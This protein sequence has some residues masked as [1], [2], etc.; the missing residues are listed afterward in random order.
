MKKIYNNLSIV[1][2]ISVIIKI[3]GLLY[4]ILTTRLLGL[5]GM[6]L[7]SL[8]TPLLSLCL[9]ISS[10]SIQQVCNQ[11]ISLNLSTKENK[12]STIMLS[13]LKVTLTSSSIVSIFMLLSFPLYKVIYQ[14]SFIYYPLLLNIP[15]LYFSNISGV[16]KGYLEANNKFLVPYISNLIESAF[17]LIVTIF[18]LYLL[19]NFEIRFQIIIC[20]LVLMLSELSSCIYLASKIKKGRHINLKEPTNKFEFQIF[21]QALP[22]TM[23]SLVATISG[24][25]IPFIYYFS[26]KRLGYSFIEATTY[27]AL[28]TAYAIPLLIN[29]QFTTLTLTKLIFPSVTR[30]R[31]DTKALNNIINQAL[32]LTLIF[33][34][35]SF[36]LCYFEGELLLDIMYGDTKSYEVVKKLA[37]IYLFLYFDPIFICILQ[38]F[39]KEK[40]QLIITIIS[41]ITAMI[42]IFIFSQIPSINLLGYIIGISIASIIKCFFLGYKSLKIAKYNPKLLSFITLIA[43][44]SLYLFLCII[45]N[46]TLIYLVVTLLYGA[47]GLLLFYAFYNKALFFRFDRLQT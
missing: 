17:K 16:M 10:F 35:I 46:S 2:I 21:K 23:D 29:G 5:E 38:A 27:Y 4:K 45:I 13:C 1:L 26:V 34:V 18:L 19:R 31:N 15:L 43:L 9:S 12:T 30:F 33:S 3:L 37:I 36:T 25:L 8:I 41:Q 42:I 20:Y 22:L 40:S 44:S 32:F 28:A 39:N 11:N 24:Y 14:E 47:L 6:R 7:I